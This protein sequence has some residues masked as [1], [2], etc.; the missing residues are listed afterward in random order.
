MRMVYVVFV[1][2]QYSHF[3][4]HSILLSGK[5][6]VVIPSDLAYGDGG[7]SDVIPGGAT[8]KFDVELIHVSTP[9][10]NKVQ[11]PDGSTIRLPEGVKVRMV[12]EESV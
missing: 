9:K 12:D 7:S 11:L 6:T 8:L 3:F 4:L 2:S 5:A 1:L 10:E